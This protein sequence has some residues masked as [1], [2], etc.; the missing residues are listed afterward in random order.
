MIGDVA[1]D[2][3]LNGGRFPALAPLAGGIAALVYFP[4]QLLGALPCGSDGPPREKAY[5]DPA[6][7]T[8]DSIIQ[9]ER[10]AA[11]GINPDAEPGRL[12]V[13]VPIGRRSGLA[14]VEAVDEFVIERNRTCLRWLPIE[15]G[16][17]PAGGIALPRRSRPFSR[18]RGRWSAI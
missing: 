8:V 6:L 13:I 5:D 3:V 18:L 15:P 9:E 12:R 17:R 14:D 16:D 10:L 7:A 11:T 1:V 4:A 2:Q